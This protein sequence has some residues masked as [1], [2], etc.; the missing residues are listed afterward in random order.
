MK[1][2]KKKEVVAGIQLIRAYLD[3]DKKA[4]A[5]IANLPWQTAPLDS[6]NKKWELY[7]KLN[8]AYDKIPSVA[9]AFMHG[10]VP[11]SDDTTMNEAAARD[12]FYKKQIEKGVY[13]RD[14]IQPLDERGNPNPDFVEHY[15]VANYS[16]EQKEYIRDKMGRDPS[17]EKDWRSAKQ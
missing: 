16:P 1:S 11:I 17:R 13:G 8:R 10:P 2:P 14:L 6:W 9:Q 15:G 12:S 5:E 7:E 3:L 4:T